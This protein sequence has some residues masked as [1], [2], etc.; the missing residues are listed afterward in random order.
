VMAGLF[1][2]VARDISARDLARALNG[3]GVLPPKVWVV[4][5]RIGSVVFYLEPALRRGLEPGRFENVGYGAVLARLAAAPADI[6]VAVAT[7]D[8][9]R[10]VRGVL[11]GAVPYETAGRYRLY[12]VG[13][14]RQH[15]LGGK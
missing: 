6:L 1:P 15:L 12:R 13:D 5:E 8:A 10:L 2:T 7:R 14:L 11:G 3:R 4:D 9:D